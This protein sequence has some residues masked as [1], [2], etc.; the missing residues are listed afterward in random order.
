MFINCTRNKK[1][2]IVVLSKPVNP[3]ISEDII[4]DETDEERMLVTSTV[5][6]DSENYKEWEVV[7]VW[8]YSLFLLELKD[9]QKIYLAD[10][11]DILWV[12]E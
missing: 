1:T 12:I 9:W 11:D 5:L 10:E 2:N 6:Q 3:K 4:V 8:K 7:A